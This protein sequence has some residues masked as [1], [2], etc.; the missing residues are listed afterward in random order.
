MTKNKLFFL[1][2]LCFWTIESKGIGQGVIDDNSILN[3]VQLGTS[4]QGIKDTLD[5]SKFIKLFPCSSLSDSNRIVNTGNT[6]PM[7]IQYQKYLSKNLI[8][9]TGSFLSGNFF[10]NDNYYVAFFDYM[11][12]HPQGR[13]FH[14]LI[15]LYSLNGTILKEICVSNGQDN[16]DFIGEWYICTSSIKHQ[17]FGPYIN[18]DAH[19]VNCKE[20]IYSLS[21]NSP[22]TIVEERHYSTTK[23]FVW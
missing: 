18:D 6:V 9:H 14:T 15:I 11:E 5:F 4:N 1:V 23:N 12:E 19:P 22:L 17:Y 3:P 16:P 20:T 13:E 7:K 21:P 10:F 2:L 8:L